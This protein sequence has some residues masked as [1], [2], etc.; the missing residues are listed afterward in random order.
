MDND[1]PALSLFDALEKAIDDARA[2][3]RPLPV[4]ESILSVCVFCGGWF[5]PTF[6]GM[7]LHAMEHQRSASPTGNEET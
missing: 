2:G 4:D 3:R 6:W 5:S 1:Q 7:R